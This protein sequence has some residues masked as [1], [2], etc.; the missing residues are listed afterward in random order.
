MASITVSYGF[1]GKVFPNASNRCNCR[2]HHE[3]FGSTSRQC[4]NEL[5]M[6]IQ[7]QINDLLQ[8][9]IVAHIIKS[10]PY[11]LHQ[12]EPVTIAKSAVAE[13]LQ[14]W[15]C[16]AKS[17]NF[18]LDFVPQWSAFCFLLFLHDFLVK[19]TSRFFHLA[20]NEILEFRVLVVVPSLFPFSH[21]LPQ[22]LQNLQLFLGLGDVI[23]VRERKIKDSHSFLE[24][25]LPDFVLLKSFPDCPELL[26]GMISCETLGRNRRRRFELLGHGFDVCLESSNRLFQIALHISLGR[27]E[28]LVG[29]VEEELE[30]L[31]SAVQRTQKVQLTLVDRNFVFLQQAVLLLDRVEQILNLRQ[32][33]LL[34]LQQIYRL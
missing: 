34:L 5:T 9:E 17:V 32:I 23:I 8:R 22:R 11:F 2:L 3:L 31:K 15:H 29:V 25:R 27:D 10:L 6:G 16:G 12:R 14:K 30:L 18:G 20:R 21:H 4:R 28:P 19:A 33:V 1:K 7:T 26:E 24:L 13:I